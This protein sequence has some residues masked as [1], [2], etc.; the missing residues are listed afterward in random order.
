MKIC[1]ATVHSNPAFTPLALMYLKAY[2]VQQQTLAAGDVRILE[3]S[4][5]DSAEEI[6]RRVLAGEPSIVGLSCY[7]WNIKTL[8]TASRQIKAVRPDIRIVLGGPEV[9]P[10][11]RF[12]LEQNPSIDCIVKSEGELPFNEIVRTWYRSDDIAKVKGICFR[13]GG[14]VV[15]TADAA[16]VHDLNHLASPAQMVEVDPKGRIICIETQ[17]GCVFRCNFCFYNKDLSIR[18]R[19]FD[20]DRVRQEIL[21]WLQ[22]DVSQIYLMDPIFNLNAA[23]AKEICR[24]IAE[25]NQRR[26]EFHTEVWAEFID[27]EMAQLMHEGNFRFLEVG[28]QTTDETVLATV[29]RRL[30]LAR[31]LEGIDHL[32][33]FGVPFE[34]QLIYGLPGET[35]ATFRAS[36]N[37]A[38]SLQPPDLAVFPLMVLPGTELRRKA[39][40][41]KID[42]DPEPPYF[43]RSHR[44]M[45]QADMAYG[46]KVADAVDR[47]GNYW[48]IRLL[49][50]EAGVT[51]ADVI[52]AWVEWVEA[53]PEKRCTQEQEV[54][55]Q[56]VLDFCARNRIPPKFYE[57]SSAIEFGA[58]MPAAVVTA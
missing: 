55:L 14:D 30:E 38:A 16:I 10:V 9:G 32:K 42:F 52:D 46:L 5:S 47:V 8:M 27:E 41:L 20:L 40:A 11:A 21:F 24:F 26:I 57:A 51:F 17:R 58:G 33:R 22:Q 54:I 43:I 29:E 37:F 23:R 48:T 39:A 31:F 56:F 44:S 2:L 13:R 50:R 6:A 53:E 35:R 15:E 1:L 19:R 7:V 3:F 4:Q 28:L 12:V 49:A 36:L 25:H 34:V 45:T 18:N